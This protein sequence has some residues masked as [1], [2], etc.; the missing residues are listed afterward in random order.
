[1]RP[2]LVPL[3]TAALIPGPGLADPLR[4][5]ALEFFAPLPEVLAEIDG[6]PVTPEQ[7]AL[8][9]ALFH[10]RRLSSSGTMSCNTC[11]SLTDGG[12]DGLETWLAPDGTPGTRNTPSILNAVLNPEQFLDGREED[13]PAQTDGP[14]LASLARMNAPEAVLEFLTGDPGYAADFAAAFPGEAVS[15]PALDRALHAYQTTLLT[16][17]PFDAWLAGDDAALDDEQKAGLQ[18]FL[19]KGCAYCHYGPTLGGDGYYPLGL[20][21][22]PGSDVLSADEAERFALAEGE[23]FVFRTSPLRNVALTGPYFHSG[24]ISDLAVAVTIMAEGQLGSDLAPEE[25]ALIVTFL[26]SLTGP[27]PEGALP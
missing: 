14:R 2:S 9:K 12:D 20:V 17:A 7:I 21:E 16:P 23:D 11:H 27:L 15:L 4:D 1:M 24:K 26:G 6:A 10:D 5:A 3:L 8:G 13:L 25:A 22:K 19:D 18:L